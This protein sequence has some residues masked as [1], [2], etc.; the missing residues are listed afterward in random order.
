MATRR[1]PENEDVI[2]TLDG[3]K[4]EAK[5]ASNGVLEVNEGVFPEK[6]KT[7]VVQYDMAGD[8][9]YNQTAQHVEDWVVI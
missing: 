3:E 2:V 9:L 6:G 4:I 5:L 8:L 1:L 7:V